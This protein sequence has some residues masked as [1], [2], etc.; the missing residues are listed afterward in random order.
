MKNLFDAAQQ[1]IA[2]TDIE[3]K[4]TLTRQ[5][6]DAL[7]AAEL[8][9][10]FTTAVSEIGEP[11]RPAK[12]RLVSKRDLPRRRTG[13]L[14]GVAALVHSFVHIEFNAINLAWDAVYRFRNMP[15][16]YYK[17]WAGVAAEEAV[18]FCLLRDHLRTLGYEYG[19]FDAHDGLWKLSIETAHDPLVRMAIVPRVMEA[20]GLDVTP[21]IIQRFRQIGDEKAA[22]ILEIILH[23]EIGHVEIG[24]RWFN[25]ICEQRGLV[26]ETT[27]EHLLVT[28]VRDSIAGPLDVETRIKA[29]FNHKE[30][31]LLERMV[32]Q[33]GNKYEVRK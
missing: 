15:L 26:R 22:A 23:D 30:L 14:K 27:F 24:S 20:R 7:L 29:G 9:I 4:L 16:D 11:G 21:A 10:E 6:H 3:E 33:T 8:G 13:S 2:A 31:A 32:K 19:D 5:V 18:H 1:C 17:D 12:P 28:Y 25:W